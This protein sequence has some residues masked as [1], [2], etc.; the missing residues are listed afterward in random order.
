MTAQ[1]LYL[2]GKPDADALLATDPNALLLGMVLD[3]QIP[4]EKAFSG[5][6]VIAERMGGLDVRAIAAADPETFKAM[7][8]TPPAV[9]RFPG[10]MAGRVQ[11]VCQVLVESYDGDAANIWADVSSGDELLRRIGA[12]PGFGAQKAGIFVALLGKQ[13]GVTPTGWREAAGQ[14]G[15]DGAR[16][17]VADVVDDESLDA[18]RATKKAVKAAAKQKAVQ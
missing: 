5:P 14:W 8:A 6:A 1:S 15:E 7:F 10:S 9:H 18:V 16:R 17:S 13:Y 11:S 12:L 4:M 3:Q 2:T